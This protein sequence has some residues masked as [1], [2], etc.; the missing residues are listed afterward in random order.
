MITA[1]EMMENNSILANRSSIKLKLLTAFS[2]EEEFEIKDELD[3]VIE[4]G[5]S[6]IK[7][8]VG[9]DVNSDLKK[10][11]LITNSFKRQSFI[12]N[13]CKPRIYES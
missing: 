2:A 5:F 1:I 10:L 8:K 6:T 12:K 11:N 4:E 3:R 13:R 9:K 7:I